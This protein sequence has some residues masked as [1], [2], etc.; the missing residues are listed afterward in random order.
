MFLSISK[1]RWATILIIIGVCAWIPYMVL[2]YGMGEDII[3]YPFLA[4]HLSG[5]IPGFLLRRW[6]L[7]RRLVL[8]RSAP[9][10]EG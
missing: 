3:V 5:V 10:S 2:K 7:I 6:G 1:K 4:V 9:S 8:R